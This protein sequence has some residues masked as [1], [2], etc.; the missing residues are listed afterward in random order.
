MI[1]RGQDLEKSI[2]LS[3]EMDVKL[4]GELNLLKTGNN[5]EKLIEKLQA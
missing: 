4:L 1:Y 2:P 5:M 3:L